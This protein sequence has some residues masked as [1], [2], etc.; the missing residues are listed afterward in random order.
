LADYVSFY[1]VNVKN[2]K[3]LKSSDSD[4]AIDKVMGFTIDEINKKIRSKNEQNWIRDAFTLTALQLAS[5]HGL[6]NQR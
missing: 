1:W 5:S 3:D 6:P 4:E 2:E